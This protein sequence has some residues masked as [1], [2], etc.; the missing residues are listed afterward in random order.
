[1]PTFEDALE[2]VMLKYADLKKEAKKCIKKN[3]DYPD[4]IAQ[5]I[6]KE[7]SQ[8]DSLKKME[9]SEIRSKNY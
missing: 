1:M 9:I 2:E 6:N 5:E 4:L 7:F 3:L 8:L